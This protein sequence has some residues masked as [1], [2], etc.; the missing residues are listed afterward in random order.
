MDRGMRTIFLH[1]ALIQQENATV[2]GHWCLANPESP[3]YTLYHR[4]VKNILTYR[5]TRP[6]TD[7]IP[8]QIHLCRTLNAD[9]NRILP[10]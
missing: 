5:N 6:P 9:A 3:I 1:P 8:Y 4:E 2:P 10:S 7:L